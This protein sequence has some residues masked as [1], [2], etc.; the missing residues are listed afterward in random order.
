MLFERT[1]TAAPIDAAVEDALRN[2]DLGLMRGI[3]EIADY[4]PR[5]GDA[6][7]AL[8]AALEPT[9]PE[10]VLEIAHVGSTSVPGLPAKAILD[11]A[12]A[13]AG[14]SDA[15]RVHEWLQAMGFLC[16]GA[17]DEQEPKVLYGLEL[18][19]GVRLVNAHVERIGGEAWQHH[20][21]LRDVLRAN[22]EARDLYGALKRRLAIDNPEDRMAYIDGKTDF[23]VAH[24]E[25]SDSLEA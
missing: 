7:N 1:E 15:L 9:R 3:V 19:E 24:R 10:E 6:F 13:V 21:G 22:E 5:W 20:L 17:R 2:A 16:R 4:S 11:I 25:A 8:V 18:E 23:I 12:I 14:P